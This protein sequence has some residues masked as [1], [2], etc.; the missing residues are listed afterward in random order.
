MCSRAQ[1]SQQEEARP[2][3][4]RVEGHETRVERSALT[5]HSRL[6]Q[7]FE[8]EESGEDS[9]DYTPGDCVIA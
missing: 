8:G 4:G 7:A 3:S 5:L 6:R 9:P 2:V 1:Q